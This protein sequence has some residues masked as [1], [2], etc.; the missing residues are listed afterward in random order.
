MAASDETSPNNL[1]YESLDVTNEQAVQKFLDNVIDTF[2]GEPIDCWINNAG[3][4]GP[5]KPISDLSAAALQQTLDINLMGV[6]HA[7]KA[8]INNIRSA[9]ES[10]SYRN[11]DGD[12]KDAESNRRPKTCP[13]DFTL[14]NISI[15]AGI[16]GYASW[17]AYCTGK[18]AVD[19]LTECVLLEETTSS[20]EEHEYNFRAYSIAPG[21]IDTDMQ[22]T[23]RQ[24]PKSHFPMLDKFLDIKAKDTF[25]TPSYVAN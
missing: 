23:I 12:K 11:D 3:V 1:Y 2:G 24:T 15:G 25:N 16:K 21:I 13:H 20:E 9:S 8:Y 19:R 14:I 22:A 5:V 4:L 6:F 18:S 17:G 10:S 7:T